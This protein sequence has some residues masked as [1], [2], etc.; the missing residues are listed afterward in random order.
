MKLFVLAALFAV[1]L[2]QNSCPNWQ[3]WREWTDECLWLPLD[4][5]RKKATEACD[6]TID[7]TKVPKVPDIEGMPEACGHCSFKFRCRKMESKQDGC[8]ALEGE[9]QQCGDGTKGDVCEM[10]KIEKHEIGCK[11]AMAKMFMEQCVNRAD[12]P[13]WKR[14]GYEKM[15][16]MLPEMNCVEHAG[17]CYCCCHPYAP[18]MDGSNHV[19]EM[20][21]EPECEDFTAWNDWTDQCLWFPPDE[22]KTTFQSHCGIQLPQS[23]GKEKDIMSKL[24]LPDGFEM[25]ERCGYCSFK[26]KCHKRALTD[27]QGHKKCF[28]VEAKKKACGEDDCEGCGDVCTLPKLFNSCNYTSHL[29]KILEPGLRNKLRKM[30]YSMKRGL[31]N[32]LGMMPHGKCVEKDGECKCC[33]HPY[34]PNADGTACVP[35]KMCD[36]PEDA[37]DL[38]LDQEAFAFW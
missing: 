36:F 34:E 20:Q 15:G 33:C 12:L 28:P 22:L 27:A 29:R 21:R 31:V 9:S 30:P 32:M 25:P 5:I 6:I 13:D 8:F 11:Y 23:K 14:E 17:K 1:T 18:K 35:H 3:P 26:L 4:N 19:C 7:W 10:P 37:I 24:K 38:N 16:D 2:A